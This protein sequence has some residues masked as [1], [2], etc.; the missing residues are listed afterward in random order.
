[1]RIALRAAVATLVTGLVVALGFM[2]WQFWWVPKTEFSCDGLPNGASTP[3]AAA[4]EFSRSVIN[5]DTDGMC[6]VLVN[7][8]TDTELQ[9]LATDLREQLGDPTSVEQITV[10]VGEQG[11]SL[12]PLTLEGPG[13]SVELF[14]HSFLGWYRVDT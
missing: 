7:K 9:A 13:G 1:M 12:F 10:R 5:S 2:F 8:L 11:G 14:V 4:Q 3:S 6:A